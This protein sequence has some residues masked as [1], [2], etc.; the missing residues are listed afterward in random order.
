MTV[1]EIQ[2]RISFGSEPV[3]EGRGEALG[4]LAIQLRWESR[5]EELRA[6]AAPDD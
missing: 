5:L 4:W 1:S 6:L 2:T 3:D